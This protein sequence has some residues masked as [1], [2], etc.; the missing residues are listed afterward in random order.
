MASPLRLPRR[1]GAGRALR[2]THHGPLWAFL[3]GRGKSEV[4]VQIVVPFLGARTELLFT[5]LTHENHGLVLPERNGGEFQMGR[6]RATDSA[7]SAAF[8]QKDMAAFTV[9]VGGIFGWE[10]GSHV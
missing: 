2:S 3:L 8:A 4:S 7:D 5:H 1:F 6:D 9:M 10:H